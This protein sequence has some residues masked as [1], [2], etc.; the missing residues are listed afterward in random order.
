MKP[1]AAAAMLEFLAAARVAESVNPET[2]PSSNERLRTLFME[3]LDLIRPEIFFDIG[4]RDGE[5]ALAVK[6]AH[7]SA[8]C[9]AFEAN[10]RI[11]AQFNHDHESSGEITYLNLALGDAEGTTDLFIPRVSTEVVVEDEVVTT[12]YEEAADTGRSSIL[13]RT[14]PGAEYDVLSVPVTTVDRFVR[15]RK[16]ARDKALALWI[17][18]EGAA[19]RVVAGGLKTIARAAVIFIEVE[20][21]RFWEGQETTSDVLARLIELGFVPVA[22]DRE[23]YDKQFNVVLLR[24]D[25]AHL[26]I[27]LLIDR[28]S[29]LAAARNENAALERRL[30]VLEQR[31]GPSYPP[32]VGRFTPVV[33]PTFNNPTFLRSMLDQLASRQL[34]NIVVVDNASTYPPMLALL[35]EIAEAA[36]VRRF[37]TNDGPRRIWDDASV[38]DA[39]PQVFAVTD[40]DL[41]LSA[42]LPP[43]F[44][45]RLFA[46]TN[47]HRV[48]KAGFALDI[49]QP[50]QM[51]Q[52]DFVIAGRPQKIWEWER[53]FWDDE[54]E[55][56]VFRG[57][58]DTTF[59]VYN[60]EFFD[61]AAPL[62]AVRVGGD[63]T[64]T[65]LPWL[66][67]FGLPS[68]EVA[69]YKRT[70]R[71]SYYLPHD[72]FGPPVT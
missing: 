23:Y 63:F 34:R 31:A 72:N 36:T 70:N 43:D 15:E 59:A 19:S 62:A 3:L 21:H 37:P 55:P 33:I 53:Q 35:D 57:L 14:D 32:L 69:Y 58:I 39:L 64:C 52:D 66:R 49:S 44:V 20:G 67:D 42:A 1:A 29:A 7:P 10:P 30:E 2:G 56:D 61:H 71:H 45:E 68:D 60:K 4:A 54:V 24:S 16:I 27:P 47:R 17:D 51:L 25:L 26:S 22:R 50:Q 12:R 48:G 11:Y 18:V 41:R 28:K 40:P 5:S 9:F 8:A 13:R 6:R 38:F 46:L 65:H